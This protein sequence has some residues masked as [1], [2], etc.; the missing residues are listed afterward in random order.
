MHELRTGVI[1]GPSGWVAAYPF[2]EYRRAA[3][4][5]SV[6]REIITTAPGARHA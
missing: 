4:C 5:P 1:G 3:G 6:V 2:G